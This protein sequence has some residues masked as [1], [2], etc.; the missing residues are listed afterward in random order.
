[1]LFYMTTCSTRTKCYTSIYFPAHGGKSSLADQF[2]KGQL[3]AGI[4]FSEFCNAKE[5]RFPKCGASATI[6]LDI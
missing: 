4:V 5:H 6:L 2:V 1:M 3:V